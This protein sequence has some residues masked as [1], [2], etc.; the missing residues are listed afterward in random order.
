[1]DLICGPAGAQKYSST[2]ASAMGYGLEEKSF[3][4]TATDQEEG[5]LLL[6][7]LVDID[8]VFTYLFSFR[9]GLSFKCFKLKRRQNSK[10]DNHGSLLRGILEGRSYSLGK[11]FVSLKGLISVLATVLFL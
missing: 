1:M 10:S 5:F 9:F 3:Q 11:S 2:T 8:E 4:K 6:Y 7:T